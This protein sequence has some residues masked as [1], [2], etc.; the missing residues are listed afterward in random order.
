MGNTTTLT[1]AG[2]AKALDRAAKQATAATAAVG[3]AVSKTSDEMGAASRQSQ[4]YGTR[5][6]KIGAITVGASTGISDMA[7]AVQALVD[8]QQ[9]GKVRAA[10]HARALAA[11]EQA[12]LDAAQ[13]QLDLK[14]AT[15]D[16]TQA[17]L[18]AKQ[19]TRDTAQAQLDVASAQLDAKEAQAEYTQAVKEH[20]KKSLEAQRAALDVRQATED[21]AQAHLDA[22]QAT[23]DAAQAH[24]DVKQATQNSA[25]AARDAKD[26]QLDLSDAQREADPPDMQRWASELSAYGAIAVGA[27][28]TIGTLSMAYTGLRAALAAFSATAIAAQAATVAGTVATG[29]ATAAQW[30][31]NVA[32]TANPSGLIIA[33]SVALV[34]AIVWIATQ[35]TWFQDIWAAAWG[36]IKNATGAA[37]DWIKTKSSAVMDWLTGIPGKLKSAFSKVTEF[38]S[39]PYRA[40]FNLISRAWNNTVGRLRWTVPSWVPQVGGKSISAPRLPTFHD[41]GVVPGAPGSEMLAVLQ[42]GERVI[43]AGGGGDRPIQIVFRGDGSRAGELIMELVRSIVEVRGGNSEKIV[44]VMV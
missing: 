7:G 6:A 35:T 43:P 4:Q 16:A 21:V 41:G 17:H 18:D 38:I 44:G 10:A 26:A 40:A 36:W 9:R 5:M 30:A 24:L 20:G 13:A 32:M 22:K 23:E 34:A 2:D 33:A 8:F 31:W 37:W 28:S 11:V 19:A 12:S 29:I 15:R 1:F 14:Q 27:A 25:Q 39:R 3:A 42:A